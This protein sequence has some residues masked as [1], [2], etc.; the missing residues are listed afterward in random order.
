MS[1]KMQEIHNYQQ[2]NLKTKLSKKKNMGADL[3]RHHMG[4]PRAR[5]PSGH[6]QSTLEHHH[7]VPAQLI[8]HRGQRLVV[9]GHSQFL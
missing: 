9:S 4:N 3:G 7:P 5:A 1:I 8:L 2:L 6:L